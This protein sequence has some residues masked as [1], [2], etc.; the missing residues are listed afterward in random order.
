MELSTASHVSVIIITTTS[1]VIIATLR[2]HM[3]SPKLE[4]YLTSTPFGISL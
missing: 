3:A 2:H 4:D 1:H